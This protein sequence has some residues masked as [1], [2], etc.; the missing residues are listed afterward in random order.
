MRSA[1]DVWGFMRGVRYLMGFLYMDVSRL[2]FQGVRTSGGF[3]VE[4]RPGDS[5]GLGH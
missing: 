2:Q 3:R 4:C 1:G 5:G